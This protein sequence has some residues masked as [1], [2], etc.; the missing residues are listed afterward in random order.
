MDFQV[1][2]HELL[3]DTLWVQARPTTSPLVEQ[4]RAG[5]ITSKAIVIQGEAT[6][7][8]LERRASGD[9]VRV[10]ANAPTRLMFYTRYF[11]GWTATVDGNA[12]AI[13]PSGEQVLITLD[14]PPGTHIVSTRWGSTPPRVVG[15]IISLSSFIAV[16]VFLWR[17]RRT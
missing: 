3:G 8:L 11:P 15:A 10:V 17:T 13:E 12:V 4:Y 9:T 6:I 1:K 2:D 5:N 16:L 7:E 14:V